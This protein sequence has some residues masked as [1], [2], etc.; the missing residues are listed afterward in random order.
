MFAPL[1]FAV[2]AV[3]MFIGWGVIAAVD[4]RIARRRG[5]MGWIAVLF[6]PVTVIVDLVMRAA[7]RG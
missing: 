5:G 7:H 1:I 3:Y 2:I 4:R 6:W